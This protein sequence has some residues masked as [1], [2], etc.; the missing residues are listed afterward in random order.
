MPLRPLVLLCLFAIFMS[1]IVGVSLARTR[2]KSGNEPATFEGT[3]ASK[4]STEVD[5]E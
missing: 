4:D 5:H 3:V 2:D 1:A